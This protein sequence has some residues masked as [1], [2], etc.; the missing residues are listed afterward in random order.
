MTDLATFLLSFI[1]IFGGIFAYV[2]HLRRC[3]QELQKRIEAL[4]NAAS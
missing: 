4:E 3:A 2:W 1:A